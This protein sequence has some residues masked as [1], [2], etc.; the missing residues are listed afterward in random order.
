MAIQV[1]NIGTPP[2]GMDGD[3][4]RTAMDKCND[5]FAELYSASGNLSQGPYLSRPSAS[6]SPMARYFATDVKEL[7]FSDGADWIRQ[8]T[9]G[10][11]IAYAERESNFESDAV[12]AVPGM[13]ATIIVG[14]APLL[15]SFGGT[16]ETITRAYNYMS[17]HMDGVMISQALT[18]GYGP[19]DGSSNYMTVSR[20]ARVT[21]LVPGSYHTFEMRF[22]GLSGN[23]ARLIG[24]AGDKPYM[25]IRNC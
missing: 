10:M 25:Q 18:S 14:E 9:G 20:D 3:T 22:G 7:Y 12:V 11:E 6:S 23:T 17:I 19:S 4:I 15:V 13:T 24:M 5:N 1:I 8:P 2:G 16:S 21:G